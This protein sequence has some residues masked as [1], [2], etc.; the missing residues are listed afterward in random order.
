MDSELVSQ[1][2]PPY[3]PGVPYLMYVECMCDDR[4]IMVIA[5]WMTRR[6]S[7]SGWWPSRAGL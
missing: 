1:H 2:S 5:P 6:P 3:S 4:N 7:R